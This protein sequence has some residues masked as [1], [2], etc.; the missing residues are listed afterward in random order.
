M[1]RTLTFATMSLAV[2]FLF[3]G[4]PP[5]AHAQSAR[6]LSDDASRCDIFRGLS[7]KLPPE[8][9]ANEPAV[10]P[11]TLRQLGRT[12]GLVVYDSETASAQAPA[13][14]NHGLEQVSAV[15]TVPKQLSIALRVEFE[16]NSFR[17]TPEAKQVIDR[18]ADVLKDDLMN[19]QV[20]EVIGH[21]DSTGPEHYNLSLSEKR[22]RAVQ[23]YLMEHHK[24][25][26][27]R[28]YSIGKG[29]SE[30][31]DP[32]NSASGINRRVEFKNITG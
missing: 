6:L 29:E 15:Q 18:V 32:E 7:R 2:A 20:I 24:I 9:Q 22:S 12:R 16:W 27:S 3:G 30:P 26:A 1:V 13:A 4:G 23:Q 8:C 17:L 5:M 21:A 14:E 28:L 31:L 25:G 11:L 19:E 10:R